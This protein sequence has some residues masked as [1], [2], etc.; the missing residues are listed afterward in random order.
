MEALQNV[1]ISSFRSRILVGENLQ[2]L[3]RDARIKEED[4]LLKFIQALLGES[5]GRYLDAPFSIDFQN[6]DSPERGDILILLAN[7]LAQDFNFDSARL[8]RQLLPGNRVLAECVEGIQ[9]THC[10]SA[11]RTQARTGR[12]VRHGDYLH[13]TGNLHETKRFSDEGVFNFLN[14]FDDLAL[15]VLNSDKFI[16]HR[17]VNGD[18]HVLVNGGRNDE[19]AEPGIVRWQVGA[20]APE[21]YSERC[22]SDDHRFPPAPEF[23]LQSMNI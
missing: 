16:H 22:A 19:P 17:S 1:R 12:N 6:A 4:I 3:A 13:G 7:W 10:V 23:P 9:K 21:G 18:E 14:R 5:E 20:A 15:G 11:R 2:T 8:F